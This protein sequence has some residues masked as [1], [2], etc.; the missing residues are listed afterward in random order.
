MFKRTKVFAGVM[1][2]L[3][4]GL[5]VPGGVAFAQT[6][7]RVEIT[8]SAIKRVD[9]EGSLPITV[10][11]MDDLVKQGVTSTEQALSRIASIQSS[12]QASSSIGGTTGGKS[13][14]DL[15]GLGGPTN[16]N[17]NKTLILL[18][19]RRLANHAFDAAAVDLN[20]IPLAAIDRIEV[21]RDGASSIYGSDAIG[22]VINFITKREYNGLEISA[23]AVKPQKSGGGNQERVNLAAGFGSLIKDGFNVQAAVDWRKQTVLTALERSFS[24]TGIVNGAISAG[25]SGTSFPGD[26]GGFEPTLPNCAP[27]LSIPNER[28]TTCRYDFVGA[29]D[30]LP[31]TEQITA[32]IRGSFALGT[33]NTAEL[34][35]LRANNKSTSRVAP[36]PTTSQIL[37]SSP[38]W[39]AGATPQRADGQLRDF[40]PNTPG[41][42]P[43]SAVN[44]RQVPAGKRTSGDDTTTERMLAAVQGSLS[45]WDYRTAVGQNRNKST[46]SVKLGYV[47]DSLVRAGV[48]RG[49]INPLGDQTPAG[50]AA[51]DAAQVR[52]P[53]QIGTARVNFVDFSASTELFKLSGGSAM[54]A[55][56]AEFRSEKSS[57]EALPITAELGSL[58]IDSESDTAGSRK[59]SAV[60][61]EMNFPLL[62]GLDLNLAGRYDR[63]NDVGNTF[64][65]KLSLRYQPVADLLFRGSVNSGFRA[66]SLYEIYQPQSLSFTTDNYDDPLLCPGGR[67]VRPDV[68]GVACGQQVLKRSVGPAGNGKSASVLKPE[69][70][71]AY[72]MGVVFQVSQSVSAGI[73]IWSMKI[74]N[75]VSGL[76]EQEIFGSAARYTS[77]FVRCGQLP[78]GPDS[79]RLDRTDA[80]VCENFPS[81]DPIAFIDAPTENLGELH[82]SGLDVAMSWRSDL[83]GMGRFSASLDGTYVT[84]YDYQRELGGRFINAVG[85]YSDNSPIFRWQHTANLGWGLGDW[86]VG[87][88][89]RYKS[90]YV[91]QD[92]VKKVAAY[93]LWDTSLTWNGIKGLSVTAAVSNLLDKDP[94][95]TGQSSTF[96]RGYDP[97]F[98]DPIGR[99]YML[100]ASYKFF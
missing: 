73:D 9:A 86:S 5:C 72:S 17:A 34:E 79:G 12:F 11:R 99:A 13:E 85:R 14:A 46:A 70:S 100:R 42:Q 29:I 25:T 54:L 69:K 92:G 90:G 67:P 83:A 49:I 71:K 47:N 15:R 91:D 63:Y 18:N 37:Q 68:E 7:D 4:S 32:L 81:F 30:I 56:G 78:A 82:T 3:G 16:A 94:P 23:Q 66:P 89:Q 65:P 22:G 59:V 38:F 36:A 64:N 96:Q 2:A 84:K 33:D 24:K 21:L 8:G 43:G 74:K 39:P 45:G 6:T 62:K 35:Y 95:V 26:V 20:A 61:A 75:L 44:W 60:F 53:T 80:D 28:K 50:L 52:E 76:P 10:V 57:F 19:G 93:A 55:V 98:T 88:A 31:Q 40:D 58:G 1:A 48:L 87:L 97:R 51:I 41:V 77:R 27:P